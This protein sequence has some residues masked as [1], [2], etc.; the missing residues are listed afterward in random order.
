MTAI[1]YPFPEPDHPVIT[2]RV[3]VEKTALVD[4]LDRDPNAWASIKGL[5]AMMSLPE[6]TSGRRVGIEIEV[7]PGKWQA[8]DRIAF[9]AQGLALAAGLNGHSQYWVFAHADKLPPWRTAKHAPV[10]RLPCDDGVR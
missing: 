7:S 4:L 3:T 9:T 5:V 2:E 8:I 6:T 1:A 10:N